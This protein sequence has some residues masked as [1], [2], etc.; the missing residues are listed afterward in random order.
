MAKEVAISR[1]GML[2]QPQQL[3]TREVGGQNELL[4]RPQVVLAFLE[5]L[6][7]NTNSGDLLWLS[8]K[9]TRHTANATQEEAEI[10]LEACR[11]ARSGH[12]TPFT[13]PIN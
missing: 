8:A 3:A 13:V 6:V 10:L 9:A 4:V 7:R 5:A 1:E 2:Q 11:R 12:E